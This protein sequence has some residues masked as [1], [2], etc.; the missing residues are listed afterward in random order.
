MDWKE[1]ITE[2]KPTKLQLVLT[3]AIFIILVLPRYL[4]VCIPDFGAVCDY[5]FFEKVLHSIFLPYMLIWLFVSQGLYLSRALILGFGSRVLENAILPISDIITQ[6]ILFLIS[7]FLSHLIIS[8]Y[9]K[10]K[11]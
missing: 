6:I 3:F 2:F 11:R 10:F 5:S 1:K 4:L 9:N 8:G 7:Y